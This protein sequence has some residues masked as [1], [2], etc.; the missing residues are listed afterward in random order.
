MAIISFSCSQRKKLATCHSPAWVVSSWPSARSEYRRPCWQDIRVSFVKSSRG[1]F[2]C[3][4]SL[5]SVDRINQ[6]L[7]KPNQTSTLFLPTGEKWVHLKSWFLWKNFVKDF[8]FGNGCTVYFW[9]LHYCGLLPQIYVR[10][11]RSTLRSPQA[12]PTTNLS[13]RIVS[14]AD[15]LVLVKFGFSA[16]SVPRFFGVQFSV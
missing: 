16:L 13:R 5:F 9:F 4:S 12:R 14:K 8:T 10:A 1:L 11:A 2:L 7:S 6:F 15:N 3:N